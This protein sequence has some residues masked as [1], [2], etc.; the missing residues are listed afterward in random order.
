MKRP[1]Y[2]AAAV[3]CLKSALSGERDNATEELLQKVENL[4]AKL[5]DTFNANDS[6]DSHHLHHTFFSFID[7]RKIIPIHTVAKKR[8]VELFGDKVLFV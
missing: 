1:E 6:R 4:D 7:P 5:V 3:H 2:V 8:F